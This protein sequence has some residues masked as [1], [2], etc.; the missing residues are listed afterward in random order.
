MS[1]SKLRVLVLQLE[2]PTWNQARYWSYSAQLALEEGLQ[3]HGVQFFTLTTPWLARAPEICRGQ[4]FDQVWLELV[5]QPL[6]E[7]QL[8]WI[9]GLAPV[10]VGLLPESL[11]YTAEEYSLYPWLVPR[12]QLVEGR[13]QYITHA[14]AVDE[15]DVEEINAR[16]LA[17]AM[18]WPQAVPER[19][20]LQREPDRSGRF[21]TFSG[22]VYTER[23][24]WLNHPELSGLLVKQASS[25]T[26]TPYPFLF[27]K[28]H[29]AARRYIRHVRVAERAALDAYLYAL[30]R[31][32]RRCFSRW[33]RKM[34]AGSA[35]INLPAR[36]KTYASRVVEGIAAGV[37]VISWEVPDRPRTKALF[38]DGKDI[39]LYSKADPMQLAEHIRHTLADPHFA[40]R[41]A[42]NARQKLRRYHTMEHRM[43]DILVWID[44]GKS[45][46][47]C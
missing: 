24:T 41:L 44:T 30:R 47:Y 16:R 8:Q 28:L 12:K 11:E 34:Q 6:D 13:L 32:R 21:A 26:G 17:S 46:T 39:L 1:Y 35:V 4:Q 27:D 5:Q 9:A 20:I 33:L 7:T 38:E 22:E 37:P 31:I 3:A 2:F 19:C 18:W 14:V 40:Q 23:T 29:F 10:R 45:A 42:A 15:R 36:V 43:K 25:E